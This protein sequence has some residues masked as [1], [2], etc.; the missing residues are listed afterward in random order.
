MCSMPQVGV[1]T[2]AL[3][4]AANASYGAK[5]TYQCIEGYETDD[6]LI[7]E[8]TANGTWSHPPPSCTGI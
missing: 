1:N 2:E 7:V 4:L 5:Y 6:S 8:C 3:A